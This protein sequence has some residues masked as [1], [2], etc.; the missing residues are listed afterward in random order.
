M[1]LVDCMLIV[2]I[3]VNLLCDFML[4]YVFV[5][6]FSQSTY[7]GNY[8]EQLLEKNF[9]STVGRQSADR[10]PSDGRQVYRQLSAD[11]WPTVGGQAGNMQSA[12][13]RPT[14]KFTTIVGR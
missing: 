3:L 12:D 2:H 6:E 7:M 1:T 8:E 4:C 5:F 10:L 9:R 11:R 14:I 13:R